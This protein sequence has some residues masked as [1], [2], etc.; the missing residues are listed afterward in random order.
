LQYCSRPAATSLGLAGNAHAPCGAD[1]LVCSSGTPAAVPYSTELPRPIA[2][3]L[4]PGDRILNS[5]VEL[6]AKTPETGATPPFVV[7]TGLSGSGKGTVL[8]VF[9]DL[10]YYA[11]DNLPVELI[12]TF[13]ELCRHSPEIER[14]ALVVDARE[15]SSL[16]RFPAIYQELKS[17]TEAQMIFLEAGDEVLQRRFSETRRPHPV[18]G[19]GAVLDSIREE[20]RR[21][22]PIKTLAD[23]TVDTSKYGIHDLRRLIMS[24]FSG[25]SLGPLLLLTVGS[26]G[27]KHGLPTESDLVFDVRFLPNPHYLPGGKDLTGNDE[28]VITYLNA[29]PQTAEFISR[30]SSLLEYLLPSYASEGK[31]YLTVN[32]GCTGGRH[33][34]VMISEAI[35]RHLE[36]AGYTVRLTHRDIHK[37]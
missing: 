11:V 6:D 25:E 16:E 10:G 28:R 14:A 33:R 1:I 21:L 31:S 32:F 26:F 37:T 29:F 35:R 3:R 18:S 23:L 13:A 24:R 8:R 5:A 19:G 9:E 20:R 22:E 15:G 17:E 7:L 34:S 27:F 4:D 2:R 36:D 12:P 30:V